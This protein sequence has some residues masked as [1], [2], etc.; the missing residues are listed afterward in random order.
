MK[1]ENF[2]EAQLVVNRI[3]TNKIALQS[4]LDWLDDL[5]NGNCD[6]RSLKDDKKIYNLH[7]TEWSDCSGPNHAELTGSLVQTEIIE[8]AI[9]KL[10]QQ[11]D[12]DMKYL[13]TL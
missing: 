12:A 8:F 5:P 2:N 7:L 11:I 3:H 9:E 13:G 10:R 6:G 1:F 4:L